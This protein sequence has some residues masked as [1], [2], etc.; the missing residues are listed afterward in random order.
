MGITPSPLLLADASA[1][2]RWL[3]LKDLF[4]LGEDHPEVSGAG[5]AAC[6]GST[7]YGAG[8]VADSRWVMGTWKSRAA[9]GASQSHIVN[10]VCAK[11][12]GF[13]GI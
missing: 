9:V 2:L 10:R 12:P 7:G 4:G 1:C 13:P 8:Q 5:A 3:V 11:P 6:V